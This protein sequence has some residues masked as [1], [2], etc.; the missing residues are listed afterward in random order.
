MLKRFATLVIS[1]SLLVSLAPSATAL[2][3]FPGDGKRVVYSRSEHRVWLINADGSLSGTWKVTGNPTIPALGTYRIYSKSAVTRSVN[4]QW[5]FTHMV[6]FARTKK[7]IGVGFH[8]I[9]VSTRTRAPIMPLD[10]IGAPGYQSHGCVR[11]S[12][13]DAERMWAWATIGTKV[14]VLK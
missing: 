7:G 11:Q 6:R 9:P 5:L 14:V 10:K 1:V 8:S 4:G 12:K 13:A 3:S 2:E